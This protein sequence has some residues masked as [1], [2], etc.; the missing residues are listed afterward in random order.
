MLEIPDLWEVLVE[1]VFGGF[2]ISVF[3]MI[4]IFW[5]ILSIGKVS[6]WTTLNFNL[7]FLFCMTAAYGYRILTIGIFVI[8]TFYAVVSIWLRKLNSGGQI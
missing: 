3:G 5:I 7:M 4:M 1:S 2:W 8:I 6:R